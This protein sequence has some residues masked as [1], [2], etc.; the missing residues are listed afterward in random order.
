MGREIK[1]FIIGALISGGIHLAI[2]FSSISVTPALDVQEIPGSIEISLGAYRQPPREKISPQEREINPTR[3]KIETLKQEPSTQTEDRVKDSDVTNDPAGESNP[4][5]RGDSVLATPQEGNPKPLYP[6]VARRRGYEGTVRL[7]VEVLASGRVGRI[8][9]KESSGY[10]ILDRS[11]LKTIEDW[12]FI[13]A[14]FGGIPV[15]S[16]VIVPVT[17][18]LK[19]RL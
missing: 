12:R 5:R 17:F 19:D 16:T 9:V 1:R 13:P 6:E 8:W 3:Q 7:K 15:K 2:F 11:A 18:E 10:E 14:R 4:D